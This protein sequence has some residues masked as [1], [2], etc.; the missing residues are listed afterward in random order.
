[1][2][3]KGV[4]VYA[5]HTLSVELQSVSFWATVC[6]TVCRSPYAIRPFSVLSVSE[7]W[8]SGWMDQDETWHGGIKAST[9]ATLC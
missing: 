8:P 9:P 5:L 6:K 4:Y 7:L 1:M 2:A 3:F